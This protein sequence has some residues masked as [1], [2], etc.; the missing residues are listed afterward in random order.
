MGLVEVYWVPSADSVQVVG[1]CEVRDNDQLCDVRPHME[2]AMTDD[3]VG[4]A[5][6]LRDEMLSRGM[7]RTSP[8]GLAHLDGLV[9]IVERVAGERDKANGH[10]QEGVVLIRDGLAIVNNLE[11]ERDEARIHAR[12]H[13][14]EKGCLTCIAC[15]T[16]RDA[17]IRERDEH[18]CLDPAHPDCIVLLKSAADFLVAKIREAERERDAEIARAWESTVINPNGVTDDEATHMC[19][20]V[21]QNIAAAIEEAP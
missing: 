17:A 4:E 7:L 21:A 12:D 8:S 16:E 19:N 15:E 11:A 1:R 3:P 9:A 2:R 5:R 6:R 13:H 20:D 14:I 10:L 18:V